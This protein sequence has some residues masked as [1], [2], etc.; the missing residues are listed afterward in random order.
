MKSKYGIEIPEESHYTVYKLTDP[1]G[2]VYIGCT[3]KPIEQ[4][5][6]KGR[7]Y[8]SG[9]P[10]R[11]AINALGWEAFEK[12]VLCENLTKE[13]AEKLEK[14]FIAYYDSSDPEKGYNRFLG[15]LGKGAHM[16]EV[17]KKISSAS[18]NRLYEEK[19]EVIEKIRHTVNTMFAEDPSYRE[20]VRKGVR[21]AYEE[22]PTIRIRLREAA[23]R[24]WNDPAQRKK[25]TE[26]R[27]A[28]C[29]G[30]TDLAERSRASQ[31]RFYAENPDRREEVRQRMQEYLSRPENRAFVEAD[32]RAKPVRCVETGE[33]F[34]SQRAAEK[35]IGFCGIHKVCRGWQRTCGGYH[36]CC[37]D[38]VD[39]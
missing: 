18:K 35:A 36:W 19:P 20:R 16:S 5:W 38:A 13:G 14:W 26:T 11:R 8:S 31:K 1:E 10:I 27:A 30:N 22:D 32:R 33:V 29:V 23:I 39:E 34:R 9:T 28:A 25:M 21:K 6:R 37:L 4:R 15:G 2:K 12:T 17:T 3:G 7:G 24:E